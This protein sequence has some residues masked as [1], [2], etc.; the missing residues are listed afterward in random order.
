M[1]IPQRRP[2]VLALLLLQ[3]IAGYLGILTYLQT[4]RGHGSKVTVLVTSCRKLF[5]IGLSSLAFGHP[6]TGYHI[7]GVSG[8]FVGVVLNAFRERA[9]SRLLVLPALLAVV[10]IVGIELK[11]DADVPMLTAALQPVRALLAP[12]L[13]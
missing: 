3:S 10:A 9:C 1:A 2:R 4:V 6:L 8:V 11:L 7:A 13:L 5:T 12:R